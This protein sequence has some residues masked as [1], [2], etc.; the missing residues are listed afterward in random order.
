M[1][2]TQNESPL[3]L[4]TVLVHATFSVGAIV[5]GIIDSFSFVRDLLELIPFFNF[6]IEVHS[7][8]RIIFSHWWDRLSFF[9]IIV[10]IVGILWLVG[11]LLLW[12]QRKMGAMIVL[13]SFAIAFVIN[14]Y[15]GLHP[16][17]HL[18]AGVIAGVIVIP[19]VVLSWKY[20]K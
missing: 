7:V 6:L 1:T 20:L 5:F 14:L 18:L 2:S 15:V 19:P 13:I 8:M 4:V 10:F 3:V 11:T 17:L 9:G 12:Q 16:Y